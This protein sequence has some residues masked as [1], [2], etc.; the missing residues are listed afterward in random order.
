MNEFLKKQ[1]A[2]DKTAI[3]ITPF[4]I[5]VIMGHKKTTRLIEEKLTADKTVVPMAPSSCVNKC[6]NWV[7]KVDMPN[8]RHTLLV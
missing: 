2:A 8:F 4:D 5:A 6:Q 7:T 1:L 3:P